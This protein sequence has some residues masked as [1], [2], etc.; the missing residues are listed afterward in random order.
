[1]GWLPQSKFDELRRKAQEVPA[2]KRESMTWMRPAST[3]L[4]ILLRWPPFMERGN[5]TR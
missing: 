1:M 4:P 5:A 2:E 3:S